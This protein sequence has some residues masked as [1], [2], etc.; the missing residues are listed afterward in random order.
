MAHRATLLN[1]FHRRFCIKYAMGIENVVLASCI[2]YAERRTL[3]FTNLAETFRMD[4]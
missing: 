2:K 4:S 1:E 3:K